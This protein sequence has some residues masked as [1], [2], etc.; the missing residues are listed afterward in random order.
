MVLRAEKRRKGESLKSSEAVGDGATEERIRSVGT[1]HPLLY[2]GEAAQPRLR[3]LY[4]LRTVLH[5][6]S[7]EYVRY[8]PNH[9]L[10]DE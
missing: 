9:R 8:V 1:N 7:R 2:V 4:V 3:L 10:D 5:P 6:V